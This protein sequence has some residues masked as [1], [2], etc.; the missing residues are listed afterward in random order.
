VRSEAQRLQ[1]WGDVMSE[2][3]DEGQWACADCEQGKHGLD[4]GEGRC[5]CC[6]R[7]LEVTS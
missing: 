1:R 2:P 7:K 4:D 6:S 5:L 3:C